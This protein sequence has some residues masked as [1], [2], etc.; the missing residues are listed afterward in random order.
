M[1]PRLRILVVAGL[2]GAW[3]SGPTLAQESMVWSAKTSGS[4]V[5]LGYGPLDPQKRPVFLLSCLNG[6]GIAVLSLYMPF[7]EIEPGTGLTIELSGGDR[8]V[9]IAGELAQ[10]EASGA[11]Y[12]EAAGIPVTPILDV[13]REEGPVTVKVGGVSAELPD[14]GRTESVERFSKSCKLS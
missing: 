6:V 13:L 12:G 8:T 14:H 7:P 5:T 11:I 9:P 3:L 4:F 10:D 1:I 2:V